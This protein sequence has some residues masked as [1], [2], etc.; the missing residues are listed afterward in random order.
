[1]AKILDLPDDVFEIIYK[2]LVRMNDKLAYHWCRQTRIPISM[3][4]AARLRLVCRK[5]ADW[6]YIHHLYHTLTFNNASRATKF[7]NQMTKRSNHLPR[8]RCQRLIVDC[9]WTAT[10]TTQGL[11]SLLI[12][13]T[14]LEALITLFLD[15]IVKLDLEFAHFFSLHIR[16]IRLI[17][18]VENLSV[19]RLGLQ[20]PEWI[21]T[22]ERLPTHVDPRTYHHD[23]D[24]LR[25]M[26]VI[27]RQLKS[28]DLTKLDPIFLSNDFGSSLAIYRLPAITQLD[29]NIE[30]PSLDGILSLAIALQRTLKVLSITGFANESDGERLLPVFTHLKG[31]LEGLFLTSETILKPILK[32]KFPKLRV[33]TIHQWSVPLSSFLGQEMFSSAPIQVLALDSDVVHSEPTLLVDPFAKLPK[34]RRLAFLNSHLDYSPPPVYEKVCRY[35][36][37]ECVYLNHANVSKIMNL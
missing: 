27:A 5:W 34:L 2:Y 12:N 35:H 15:T 21:T 16:T 23:S 26:I 6:L 9:L 7:L 11:E 3:P 36:R 18:R 24:C 37:V 22:K 4:V 19:L 13:T 20:F 33:F 10:G 17:G 32:F 28:L 30:W 29:I 31:T 25:S 1:M 8:A 14:V